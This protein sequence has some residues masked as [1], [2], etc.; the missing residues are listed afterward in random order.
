MIFTSI[1]DFCLRLAL[2]Y[3][4]FYVVFVNTPIKKILPVTNIMESFDAF[5]NASERQALGSADRNWTFLPAE[6]K[7]EYTSSIGF[8]LST[9]GSV[10]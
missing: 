6:L 10:M 1:T 7:D 8:A 5:R 3:L 4:V 2:I 9:G